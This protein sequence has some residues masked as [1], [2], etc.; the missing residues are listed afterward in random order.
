MKKC[1]VFLIPA[2]LMLLFSACAIHPNSVSVSAISKDISVRNAD[3]VILKKD[4]PKPAHVQVEADDEIS[5]EDIE[6]LAEEESENTAEACDS[7]KNDDNLADNDDDDEDDGEA[8]LATHP[9]FDEAMEFCEAAQGFW[10]SG[11]SEKAMAALDQAYSLILDVEVEDDIDLGRQKEDLRFL[12]SKRVLEI[13]ASRNTAVKG[14]HD[15][16]PMIM[17]HHVEAEIALLTTPGK[18]GEDCFFFKAYRRSGKYHAMIVEELKKAGLPAELAW[19]PLIE[20]GFQSNALSPARALGIWQFIPS[21]GYKYGLKRDRYVDERM[22]PE[23]ATKAA[24]DYLK[25]LHGMFGDWA[26]VL[27]AY[28]CGEGRVLRE[29]RQQ[30]INYLDNFWDLYE[31]LPRET[32]RY[33]PRFLATLHILKE[34]AK[35]GLD[36]ILLQ[37]SL[38]YD[39]VA[40]QRMVNLSDVANTMN[41]DK[42]TL[43]SL[44]PELR[45]QIIPELG[46][47]LKVPKNTSQN[48][49]AKLDE[50]PLSS[51]PQLVQEATYQYHKVRRGE[52]LSGIARQYRISAKRLARINSLG[53]HR[54]AVAGD[55]LK[56]PESKKSGA[57]AARTVK[58]GSYKESN[59]KYV[60]RKGDSVASIAKRYGISSKE[61]YRANNLSKKKIRVGQ[62]LNI[63]ADKKIAQ[64]ASA[65]KI[66]ADKRT[67]QKARALKLYKVKSGDSLKDIARQHKMQL[68]KFLKVNNLTQKSKIRPGQQLYVV[69]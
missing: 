46:Y 37:P 15:A 23:K 57:I 22:D 25:E 55:I 26:T 21:T 65:L 12:I 4:P 48:L 66:S 38:E 1:T 36:K 9:A 39:T 33:V 14:N 60:V 35:Y 3:T 56:I 58:A 31:K 63:S 43:A 18:D 17:N 69:E 16:I 45:H 44:N 19:L 52:S 7:S 62:T 54:R 34:P 42:E 47:S 24:I 49:L 13:Y 41:I 30:N 68:G 40:V 28:N 32:A 59:S 51:P 6:A 50:I 64:K 20:S 61:L 29:I 2:L 10:K 27:A 5:D 8:D 11:D 53:K 67:A